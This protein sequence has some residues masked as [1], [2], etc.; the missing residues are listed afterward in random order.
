MV[1]TIDLHN[2]SKS[3]FVDNC[4]EASC[5]NHRQVLLRDI[6]KYLQLRDSLFS[7]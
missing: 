3:L 1:L 5:E 2:T 7:R 4:L 6:F